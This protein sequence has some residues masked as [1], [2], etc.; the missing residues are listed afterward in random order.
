MGI[1]TICDRCKRVIL[2]KSKEHWRI[3][4][5]NADYRYD[6]DLCPSCFDEV[7]RQIKTRVLTEEDSHG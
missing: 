4:A 5:A 3:E 7:R 1:Q 6:Y 2:A